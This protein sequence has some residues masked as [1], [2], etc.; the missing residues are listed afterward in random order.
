MSG[1]TP[2]SDC[3]L[4]NMWARIPYAARHTTPVP[5]S[6]V[7]GILIVG[8]W[9]RARHPENLAVR[10]CERHGQ[11]LILL[12]A[13]EETRKLHLEAMAKRATEAS[14]EAAEQAVALAR[15]APF[16]SQVQQIVQAAL[17]PQVSHAEL[18]A[19]GQALPVVQPPTPLSGSTSIPLMADVPSHSGGDPVTEVAQGAKVAYQC[20][21]CGQR[22]ITGE[23]HACA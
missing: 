1:H 17:P 23:L 5:V 22:A 19:A 10:L 15:G 7:E 11:T 16:R 21:M 8:F 12:D 3:P 9:L 20:P 18:I 6:E 4:C 14:R 2:V 13:Q